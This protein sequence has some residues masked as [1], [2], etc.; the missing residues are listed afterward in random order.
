M[1]ISFHSHCSFRILTNLFKFSWDHMPKWSIH[2][3][4]SSCLSNSFS[5]GKSCFEAF[6]VNG[7]FFGFVLHR[8]DHALSNFSLLLWLCRSH[9]SIAGYMLNFICIIS[10]RTRKHKLIIFLIQVFNFTTE[11]TP[12][13]AL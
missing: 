9:D 7:I 6:K 12:H 2:G 5:N 13:L 11:D 10:S 4:I 3:L 8:G 1:N